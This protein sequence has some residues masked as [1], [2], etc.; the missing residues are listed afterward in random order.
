MTKELEAAA[1]ENRLG[2][3]EEFS[4]GTLPC[5]QAA[6]PW[7]SFYLGKGIEGIQECECVRMF[8]VKRTLREKRVRNE[9]CHIFFISC[10]EAV[11]DGSSITSPSLFLEKCC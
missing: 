10:G 4:S 3:A 7:K 1:Y 6:E 9:R 2:H 5:L 8:V 11:K